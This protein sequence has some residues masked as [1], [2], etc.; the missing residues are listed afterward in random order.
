MSHTEAA[1]M[2]LNLPILDQLPDSK[3]IL[4]S[5]AGG[6]FDIFVGL[7]LYFTLKA[8]GKTV[9]LANY[10]FCD[11]H[12]TQVASTP[13]VLLQDRVLGARGKVNLDIQYFPEG[14]L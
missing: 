11:F 10:S 1:T 12:I 9:H 6:G 5:G 14:Y 2:Q 4:I 13:E 7:P 3:S 8:L